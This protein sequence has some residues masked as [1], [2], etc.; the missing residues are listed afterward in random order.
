MHSQHNTV[1][2]CFSRGLVKEALGQLQGLKRRK[3]ALEMLGAAV[4]AG[5]EQQD[6]AAAAA[7]VKVQTTKTATATTLTTKLSSKRKLGPDDGESNNKGGEK[8]SINDVSNHEEPAT[9][10]ARTD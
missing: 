4:Q 5:L 3:K 9:K 8:Q 2:D 6:A 1:K 7:A 10:R